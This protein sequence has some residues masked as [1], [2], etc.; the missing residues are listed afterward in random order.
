[1]GRKRLML[2]SHGLGRGGMEGFRSSHALVRFGGFELDQHAGELR[3]EDGNRIRLQEQ[4][5]QILRILLEHPGTIIPREELRQKIWP[6]DTFVDFDHGINNAIKRLR[7]ALGDTAETPHYIETLPRRGYRFI[8][9]IEHETPR[10]RSLAVLPLENLSHDPEQ[11]YFADGLTEALI[12]TL[13]KIGELRVVSRTSSMLYKGVRKP[14]R[15]IA[16]E[17]EV[18]TIVEGSVLR[19]GDRV[20]ITAQLIDPMKETH[21]WAESYDR[22]L[23]DVLDLQAD[24]TRAIAHEI[25]IKLTPQEQAHL[26][27]VYP[28]DPEAYEAYLKGRYHWNKRSREGHVKAVQYFQQAIV[29]DP[30]CATAYAGLADAVAIMGLW[31]LVPPEEGCGKARGLALKALERDNSLAEAHTSLAW[32]ALHYDYDFVDAEKGFERAIALNPRYTTAHHWFGMS[33]GMMGRYEE[34]YTELKRAIRLD[35]HWSLVHFGMAFVHWCGHQYDRAI[36]ECREALGLDPNS[37]QALVWLALSS[38]ATTRF[39]PAITALHRAVELSQGAPVPIACL[40]EAY[41]AAGSPDEA[42][43]ILRQLTGQRH[44]TAYFVSRIFAALDKKSEAIEWLETAYQ[45]HGE[46]MILLKVDPRFDG[47]R[48]DARFQAVVRRINFLQ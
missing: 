24:V 9:C 4:P 2:N 14:L 34:G 5:L 12:T 15:E 43:K 44:V 23:R 18:D 13:A 22:H 35:P 45:E 47:L 8:G 38:S 26:A 7:K 25:Q 29:K 21:L 10:F 33:L 42:Q 3:K 40:G 20:R 11:E 17:L 48:D 16:R 28:V 37:V 36:E 31:G 6:S 32:A 39:E 46:W 41:A 19:A 27:Q 30:A 1:M